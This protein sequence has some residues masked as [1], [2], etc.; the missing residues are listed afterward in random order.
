MRQVIINYVDGYYKIGLFLD[1]ELIQRVDTLN[2]HEIGGIA[3]NWL[4]NGVK[5]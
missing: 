3:S 2:Y 4:V 1:S 5:H